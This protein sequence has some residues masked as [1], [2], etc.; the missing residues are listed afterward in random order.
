MSTSG[1][2]TARL[3]EIEPFP[4][5]GPDLEAWRPVR[6]RL[7]VRAFG[8]N[9]WVARAAGDEIIEEHDELNPEDAD[10]HEEL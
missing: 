3:Y 8:V 7:G 10:N 1:W 4:E 9:A 2:R 6:H 5:R